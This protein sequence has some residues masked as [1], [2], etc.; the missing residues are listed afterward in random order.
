MTR[1]QVGFDD[2]PR[3]GASDLLLEVAGLTVEFPA[4]GGTVRAVDDVSFAIG[5]GEIVGLVGESASGKSTLGL[6]IMRM[7]PAPGRVSSG[8]IE[9]DG[10]DLD[11][12]P[13]NQMRQ[14]RGSAISLIVQDAL[15]TMNPVTKIEE[16][17]G[18]VVRD[19]GGETSRKRLRVRSM[20][21]LREVRL[22]NVEQNLRRYPHELSGGMQQRVAIAEGLILGPKVIIADEPT[23]ALDV[24]VQAQILSLLRAICDRHGTSIIFVT[25]DLATVAEI[26]D[27]VMVMYAGRIVESGSVSTVF[28]RPAHPYTKALLSGLLPLSGEPPKELDALPGQ[29][30]RPENWP[31]GCRF[32]PRCPTWR[33]RGE[34]EI[35]TT[36]DPHVDETTP[37]W[38]AC[39]FADLEEDGISR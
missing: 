27:R 10:H 28:R 11:V 4:R 14:L 24:T 9:F 21:M 6:A 26:C 17:I 37:H 12:L 35:C 1:E 38:A 18:E 15:A 31:S 22:P 8:H 5:R 25:H 7:V 36:T 30:P 23:T 39:H 33:R 3:E 19:H 29:P 32:H 20:N 34:P 16:Q 13:E 2:S